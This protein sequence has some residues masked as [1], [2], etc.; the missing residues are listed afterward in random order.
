MSNSVGRYWNTILFGFVVVAINCQSNFASLIGDDSNQP[1]RDPGWPIGAALLFNDPSRI[2]WWKELLFDGQWH[3]E[4][5]G[6]ATALNRQLTSLAEVKATTKRIVLRDGTGRS[7]WNSKPN[8]TNGPSTRID[9]SLTVWEVSKFTP[10]GDTE[11]AGDPPLLLDV[12][13]DGGIR[14]HSVIVPKGIE[15]VDERLETH[16]FSATDGLVLQGNVR[17]S[18]SRNAIAATIELE[19]VEPQNGGRYRYTVTQ[20]ATTDDNGCWTMKHVANGWQRIVVR[21]NGYVPRIANEW[22]FE[23]QLGWRRFDAELTRP[24]VVSGRVVDQ[25][26]NPLTGVHV[27]A[28]GF[29]KKIGYNTPEDNHATSDVAGLFRLENVPKGLAMMHL[30]KN[31]YC[32]GYS[33]PLMVPAEKIQLTMYRSATL[34]IVVDFEG[35]E[36][37]ENYTLQLEPEGGASLKNPARF[38]KLDKNGEVTFGDLLPDRYIVYVYPEPYRPD[39]SE[40]KFASVVLEADKTSDVVIKWK[41]AAELTHD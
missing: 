7:V 34:H 26:G 12:Y 15:V 22:N 13:T 41:D 21:A 24:A 23:N 32:D 14:W 30:Q 19:R 27:R 28:S 35:M 38:A 31:N 2:A 5:R 3:A 18:A 25:D 11:R 6:D 33:Y 37:S 40:T 39:V 10:E 16:G 29:A 8:A 1:V 4:Y 17:D 9:W 20:R 36:K